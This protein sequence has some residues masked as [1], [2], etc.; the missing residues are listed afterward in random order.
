MTVAS[1][2]LHQRLVVLEGIANE[3][4]ELRLAVEQAVGP[5]ERLRLVHEA[6][7]VVSDLRAAFADLKGL[8][9][10]ELNESG[11]SYP[12]IAA[13]LGCSEPYVQQMIYRGR[14]VRA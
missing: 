4:A 2:S 1:P 11:V 7:V 5:D 8:A 10:V 6:A 9:A 3:L 14:R 13:A 12:K